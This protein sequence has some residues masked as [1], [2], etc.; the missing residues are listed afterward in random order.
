MKYVI[1]RILHAQFAY[2]M[3]F[4]KPPSEEHRRLRQRCE[5]LE[6]DYRT[7]KTATHLLIAQELS[8]LELSP[9]SGPY[10][11][12]FTDKVEDLPPRHLAR[13]RRSRERWR[14]YHTPNFL[15]PESWSKRL[16]YN[17]SA[18]VTSLG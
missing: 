11:V 10:F 17:V 6:Q 12:S 15:P 16:R 1:F 13:L 14:E 8:A 4:H 3:L 2:R 18:F 7:S 9:R 5:Q